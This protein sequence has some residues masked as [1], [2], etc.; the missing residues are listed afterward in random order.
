LD[1][2]ESVFRR[3]ILAM[4]KAALNRKET[5]FTSKLDLSLT[6]KLVKSYMWNIA[7]YGSETWRH[8]KVD[9]KCLESF[10]MCWW[11]RMEKISWTDRVKNK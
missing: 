11:R 10:E 4:A 1:R 6:N 9:K 3:V 2:Q 8:R 7:F 5:I